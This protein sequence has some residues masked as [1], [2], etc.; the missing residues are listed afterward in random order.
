MVNTQQTPERTYFMQKSLNSE[1]HTNL[2]TNSGK[3]P[4]KLTNDYL[5]RAVFQSRPKAL[6]GLCRSVLHLSAEDTVSVT[7]QNPIEL[8]QTIDSKEFI[9][10][11]AVLV[12]N[13]LY[14]NLEMQVLKEDFWPERALSSMPAA[15]LTSSYMA[16]TMGMCCRSS[17]SDFWTLNSLRNIPNSMPPISLSM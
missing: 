1:L 3:L 16:K 7:L 5:F 15:A 14:L 13:A 12:N 11:L 8:G 10:D 2:I 6:E 9:L 4:Y 17:T